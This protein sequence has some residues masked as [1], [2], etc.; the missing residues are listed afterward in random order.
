[1][2]LLSDESS[3]ISLPNILFSFMIKPSLLLQ[4]SRFYH[5]YF[6]TT[7]ILPQKQILPQIYF[8]PRFYHKYCRQV[9]TVA[10]KFLLE[11][12]LKR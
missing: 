4:Q 6:F 8:L 7:N 1:M 11:E 9:G 12:M 5:K 3:Q 10:L 2:D